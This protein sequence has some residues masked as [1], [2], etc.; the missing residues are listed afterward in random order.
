VVG[1]IKGKSAIHITRTFAGDGNPFNGINNYT[2]GFEKG[3]R[4][5]DHFADVECQ[6][7]ENAVVS[8]P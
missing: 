6:D 3:I 5:P 2:L 1:Y 4:C 7:R 8:T